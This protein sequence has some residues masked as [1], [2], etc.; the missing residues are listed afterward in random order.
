MSDAA[1]LSQNYR[2]PLAK[3][4]VRPGTEREAYFRVELKEP[5][6]RRSG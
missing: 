6:G 1:I 2:P 5:L 4:G 3:I